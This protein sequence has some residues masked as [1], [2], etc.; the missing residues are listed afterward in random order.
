MKK[1]KKEHALITAF[2]SNKNAHIT[3]Q[4]L[5]LN[6]KSVASKYMLFRKLIAHYLEEVYYSDSSNQSHYEEYYYFTGR[7]R[8]KK[9]KS[10]YDAINLIAFYKNK[11][12]YTL[13]MPALKR[14]DNE[15]EN[16]A[17]E[18]YLYWHKLQSKEAYKTPLHVFF[19]FL[20]QN[21]KKYKGVNENNFFFYLKECEF[22]YNCLIHEQ[23]AI[24]K[25]IY[26][27]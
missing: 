10:L 9:Q 16:K 17:Y 22:K 14:T 8:L 7:Q 1:L 12:V 18:R 19:A 25:S 26:Y 27:V 4:R 13:L 23:I 6:Y 24:L 20:E 5:N 15:K 21:L 11:R 3:A 2:C